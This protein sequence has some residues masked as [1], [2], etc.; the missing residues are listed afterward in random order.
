MFSKKGCHLCEDVESEIRSMRDI[1]TGL[2]VVNIDEDSVL[3]DKYWLRVPVV[4]ID[5]KD[6]FEAKMIDLEGKWKKILAGLLE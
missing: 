2:Q 5:G 3:H 6:V 4:R 1:G